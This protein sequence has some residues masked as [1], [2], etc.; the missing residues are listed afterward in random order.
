MTRARWAALIALVIAAVFAYW[1]GTFSEPNYRALRR[2][3]A[4]AAR[5]AAELQHEV[6]SLRLFRDSL[7]TNPVVQER[8]AR[9]TFGM[10]RP[11]EL[12]VMI[13]PGDSVRRDTV[14]RR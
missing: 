9:E 6:D 5:Q 4:N 3:E 11:G 13:V 7:A 2:D 8:V 10:L 12:T 14:R 1:G